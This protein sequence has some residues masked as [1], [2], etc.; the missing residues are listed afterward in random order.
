[1]P[2]IRCHYVDCVYLEGHFC[3]ASLIELDPDDGCLSFTRADYDVD[4]WINTEFDEWDEDE[5]DTYWLDD[6]EIKDEDDEF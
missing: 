2:R 3:G 6:Q 5:F 4:E 1:M